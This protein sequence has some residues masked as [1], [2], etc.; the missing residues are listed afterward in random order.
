VRTLLVIALVALA[1]CKSKPSEAPLPPA[2]ATPKEV[3]LTSVGSTLDVI[4]SRVAAAVTIAREANTAGKPTVVE[5]ELSVA[6]SFLP[7]PTEGDLAYARQRSEKAPPPDQEAQ[8]KE[9][10]RNY[11]GASLI[12]HPCSRYIWYD[13]HHYPKMESKPEW[14][15]AAEDGHRSEE[16]IANRLRLVKG[17]E[18]WTHNTHGQQ[19]RWHALGGKFSGAVDGVARGLLQAPKSNHVWENKVCNHKKFADFQAKKNEVGEK[20]ALQAWNEQYFGQAQVNMHFMKMDRH[21]TT[22]SYA[23]AR[24]IDSCRTEYQPEVA[25]RLIDKADRILSVKI[26]PPRLSDKPDFWRCKMCDRRHICH[27]VNQ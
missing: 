19:F 9:A 22:V 23:G 13:I 11:L 1:G 24:D 7:K 18:L 27:G 20:R 8:P 10:P 17:L 2:V 26:E 14:L 5:E 15:W 12:G 3:A 4:D 6:S 25:E 21:Y 16:I